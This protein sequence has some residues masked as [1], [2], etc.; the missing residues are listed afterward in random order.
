[1]QRQSDVQISNS[2][3]VI[4]Y[5]NNA[6]APKAWHFQ[7]H[8]HFI[9]Q[10]VMI[11]LPLPVKSDLMAGGF[12]HGLVFLVSMIDCPSCLNIHS[13]D[14]WNKGVSFDSSLQYGN[15]SINRLRFPK[16]MS[17][18]SL[19]IL[20]GWGLADDLNMAWLFHSPSSSLSTAPGKGIMRSPQC[21]AVLTIYWV[22]FCCCL[23]KKNVIE[24]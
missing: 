18:T 19:G 13:L 3:W 12:G 4:D 21:P 6:R 24:V 20:Q 11:S 22:F 9:S 23:F 16:Q 1:M 15:A 14:T 17:N 7:S 2:I 5:W 8:L 10:A